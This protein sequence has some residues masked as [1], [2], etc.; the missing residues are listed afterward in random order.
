MME[1]NHS[2]GEPLEDISMPFRVALVPQYLAQVA[3]RASSSKF[4]SS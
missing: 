3:R 4:K 2:T 1:G